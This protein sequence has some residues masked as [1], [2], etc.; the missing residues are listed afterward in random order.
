MFSNRSVMLEE[1]KMVIISIETGFSKE[2][3]DMFK[4]V[5]N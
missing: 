5:E 3:Y 2:E 4:F 1:I